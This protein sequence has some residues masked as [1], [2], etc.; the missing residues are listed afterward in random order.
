MEANLAAA[1][2]V[3][4]EAAPPW[5][6]ALAAAGLAVQD[7]LQVWL[8]R[9]PPF[10]FQETR[11]KF[12]SAFRTW[13]VIPRFLGSRRPLL[14]IRSRPVRRLCAK[15]VT[16]LAPQNSCRG[17]V[18]VTILLQIRHFNTTSVLQPFPVNAMHNLRS[19]IPRH[20]G[21]IVIWRRGLMPDWPM[22]F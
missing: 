14:L 9:I 2:A 15:F 4:V 11:I 8:R 21:F 17:P 12:A 13:R 20:L 16:V 18:E 10:L 3:E 1:S 7:L 22:N 5:H 19:V 6:E